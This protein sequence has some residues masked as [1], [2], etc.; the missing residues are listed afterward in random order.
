MI[1]AMIYGQYSLTNGIY[2]NIVVPV[3]HSRSSNE[4]GWLTC[5]RA[6]VSLAASVDSVFAAILHDSW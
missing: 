1:P 5:V 4:C 2:G 6:P 3:K